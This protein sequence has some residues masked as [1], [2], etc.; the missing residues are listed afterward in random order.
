MKALDARPTRI[1]TGQGSVYA[2]HR[3]MVAPM[4]ALKPTDRSISPSS[5]T[6][7]SAMPSRMNGTLWII[8]LTRLPADRNS[9]FL[10][11]KKITTATRPRMIGSAPLSPF[12]TRRHQMAA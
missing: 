6:K 8:R 12:L 1:A 7:I 5:S 2:A 9:E 11:W 3:Q 4:A 10:T